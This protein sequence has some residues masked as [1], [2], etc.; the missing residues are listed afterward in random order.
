[1]SS[2]QFE[3]EE[4]DA[5]DKEEE[6]DTEEDD[7]VINFHQQVDN[8]YLAYRQVRYTNNQVVGVYDVVSFEYDIELRGGEQ[9]SNVVDEAGEA[10]E[11]QYDTFKREVFY[12]D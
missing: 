8:S 9:D 7:H 10:I 6:K 5:E 12:D 4:E 1:M 11:F 2:F 3:D